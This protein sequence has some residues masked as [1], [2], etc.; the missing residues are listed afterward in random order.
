MI[1]T[2]AFTIGIISVLPYAAFGYDACTSS[3]QRYRGYTFKVD[4]STWEKIWTHCEFP[5]PVIDP[6]RCG[7]VPTSVTNYVC[8]PDYMLASVAEGK[9]VVSH[10]ACA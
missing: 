9:T 1:L 8:D 6:E 7:R 2:L 10:Y 3:S 5:N 4:L